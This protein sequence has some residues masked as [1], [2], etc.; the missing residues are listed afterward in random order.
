MRDGS[1]L[2]CPK[3]L[4]QMAQLQGHV[5]AERTLPAQGSLGTT[6]F[7]LLQK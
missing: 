6:L 1:Q 5:K 4:G 7:S 3:V 2:E